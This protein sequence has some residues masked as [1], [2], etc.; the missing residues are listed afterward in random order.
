MQN[1]RFGKYRSKAMPITMDL[2]EEGHVLYIKF[3]DPW[4]LNDLE[5]AYKTE[6]GLRDSAGFKLHT[7]LDVTQLRQIPPGFLAVA[8]RTPS[9]SHPR[10]GDLVVIGATA[11]AR[12]LGETLMRITRASQIKFFNTPDEGRIYLQKI[13]RAETPAPT[14]SSIDVKNPE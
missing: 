2:Q 8:K 10:R 7:L 3:A 12:V 6:L 14:N 1:Q 13:L 4:T 11:F 9:F 5:H